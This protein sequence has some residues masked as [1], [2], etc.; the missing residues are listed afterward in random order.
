MTMSARMEAFFSAMNAFLAGDSN[1]ADVE[2]ALGP[3]ASGTARLALYQTFVKRQRE[4]VLDSLFPAVKH[5]CHAVRA[6]LWSEATTTFTRAHPP[7]DWEP[8]RFG[9]SFADF[10]SR[11]AAADPS[12]PSYLEEL[13]D[14]AYIRYAASVAIEP[15]D[16]VGLDSSLYVRRY[17]HDVVAFTRAITDDVRPAPKAPSAVPRTLIVAWSRTTHTL[18]E[19]HPS[20]AVMA[21][22]GR[23]LGDDSAKGREDAPSE[24]DVD[25]A[26]R[27]LIA[28]GVL[29]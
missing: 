18:T 2:R 29:A 17:D 22:I 13:A 21:A 14:Y 25:A 11:R 24:S 4:D 23:R 28:R 8:N 15:S 6:N 20:L 10:W 3:S 9:K 7:S 5:A 12:I 16:G 26:E 27:E 19:L 1:A